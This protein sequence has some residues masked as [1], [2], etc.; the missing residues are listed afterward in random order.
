MVHKCSVSQST[1][2]CVKV[3][4]FGKSATN[5]RCFSKPCKKDLIRNQNTGRCT[6][7]R[8]IKQKSSRKIS[9]KSSK[10]SRKSSQGFF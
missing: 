9:R 8:T 7:K 6:K 10:K 5:G 4:K 3:C 2:R 1:K